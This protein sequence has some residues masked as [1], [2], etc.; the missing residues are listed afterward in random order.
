[1]LGS[2]CE[3]LYPHAFLTDPLHT[4]SALAATSFPQRR[5]KPRPPTAT[6]IPPAVTRVYL[7][8]RKT[9][10]KPKQPSGP[11]TITNGVRYSTRAHNLTQHFPRF[12]S[13]LLQACKSLMQIC[14]RND[15]V[16][17]AEKRPV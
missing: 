14:Y 6:N 1:M 10:L 8:V 4:F 2:L 3:H 12:H 11:R 9:A 16:N 17:L 5:L 13:P 15:D 7:P